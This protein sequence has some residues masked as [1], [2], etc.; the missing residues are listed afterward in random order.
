MD[1]YLE[2]AN[3]PTVWLACIPMVLL[4]CYQG[5]SFIK[6]AYKAG[7]EMGMK[8]E[9]LR[10]ALRS[11]CISA[12][13]PSCAIGVGVVALMAILGGPFGFLKLVDCGSL[14]YE[15]TNVNLISG[16][17]GTTT[18]ALNTQQWVDM[19]WT[20]GASCV[21]WFLYVALFTT[22]FD[23]ILQKVAK[24]D[25]NILNIIVMGGTIG[26]YCKLSVPHLVKFSPATYAVL[27]SAVVMLILTIIKN[28]FG[29]KWLNEWSLPISMIFGMAAS[30]I[31]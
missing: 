23:K 13:G 5:Y 29:L 19:I 6:V 22:Q 26:I 28:K 3:K 11:G 9:T 24:K 20:M 12:V 7:L 30:V 10:T 1:N 16:A 14:L 15:L 8:P 27:G 18:E 2:I 31:F 4:I 17:Y 25:D 21:F